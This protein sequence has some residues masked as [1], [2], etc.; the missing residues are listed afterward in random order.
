ME[1]F[2]FFKYYLWKSGWNRN[3]N[4][5]WRRIPQKFGGSS[6]VETSKDIAIKRV[7][8]SKVVTTED[9]IGRPLP[10]LDI[11]VINFSNVS[12]VDSNIE[13]ECNKWD[14]SSTKSLLDTRW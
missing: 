3:W 5:C 11:G 8:A 13:E 1:H 10:M 12:K 2:K 4:G 6:L 14:S 9:D 7:D